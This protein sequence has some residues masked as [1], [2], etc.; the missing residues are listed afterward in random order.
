[1]AQTQSFTFTNDIDTVEVTS[2]GAKIIIQPHD[3]EGIF[4][5]YVNPKDAPEFAAVLSGKTLTLKEQ[6][7]LRSISLNVFSRRSEE[8]TLAVKLP[9]V[10][11]AKLK[12]NTT[13]GGAEIGEVL[14]QQFE[15]NTASGNISINAFFEDIKLQSA[16]GDIT[17]ANTTKNTAKLLRVGNVSGSTTVLGYKSEKYA[18]NSV[19][20]KTVIEGAAGAGE[21]SVASGNID[22]SYA[23]WNADLKVSA[24]SGDVK[25]TLP[26]QAGAVITLDGISGTLKT[27]LG[28]AKGSFVNLGKG[29]SGEFG[30]ENKHSI[31]ANLVSGNIIVTQA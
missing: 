20:G 2:I 12:V 15:L 1:M 16:S 13:S 24:V 9:A 3:G 11:Y 8:C 17:L 23:E 6:M 30:G 10:C 28:A 14:A 29:T 27:D 21:I 26:E 5:E 31:C 25:I 4:V 18:I 22:V 19:S 7:P